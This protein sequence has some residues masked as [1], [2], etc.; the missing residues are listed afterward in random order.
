[1]PSASPAVR[2]LVAAG[3]SSYGDWLTTVA[4]LVLLY[5]LTNSP[6]GPALYMLARVAPR[7][8]GPFP[9]GAFADRF[10]AARVAATCAGVQAVLTASIVVLADHDIVWAIYVA[11]AL[12]QLFGAAAQ[13]CYTALIPRVTTPE[14]LGRIQGMY[15][16]L[17]NSSILVSPAF[18][19]L[20]LPYTT[21]QVLIGVDAATFVLASAIIATLAGF[22]SGTGDV[23]GFRGASAGIPI[24]LRDSGLRFLA[25]AYISNAAAVTTLQAVLVVA[26]AQR[27]GH[28]TAVGW[29]YAA[30]GAGSLLGA[31]P[32]I[33]KTPARVGMAI[34]IGATALE[35][36]PL[37]LF[38]FVT[39]FPLAVVL[40]FISGV[41]AASYQ[42]RGVIG[43]QQR[44]PAEL[45]GRTMAVIRSAQYIGMLFGA[46]AAV[47]LVGPLGWQA[48]VLIV[49]AVGA[50]LLFVTAVSEGS[51]ST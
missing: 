29:L 2:L 47:S 41:G 15:S 40:L 28:D 22:G 45:V 39:V 35:L 27:F 16:A 13:P 4:L 17:S 8:V 21:P 34:I 31:I 46:I 18:G 6:I 30:V 51:P 26:A 25:A 32:V 19:A 5:R 24:V 42:T 20:I 37:A 49:C 23:Q 1:V 33:R 36:V 9:G 14:R 7:V 11:V 43:L 10:G 3:T 12:A 48:A 50:T 44:V 38:V